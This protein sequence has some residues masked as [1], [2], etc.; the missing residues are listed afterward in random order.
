MAQAGGET[1]HAGGKRLRPTLVYLSAPVGARGTP[2]VEIAAAAVELVHMATLVHDDVLDEAP[3]R[4]GHPTAWSTHGEAVAV[5][6]GDYLFARAFAELAALRDPV[7]IRMLS[8]TSC[9][10]A[11]GELLQAQQA[12]DPGVAAEDVLERCRLKTG[13]LFAAACALGGRLGGLDAAACAAL[14]RFG[15]SLGLAFQLAD[16]V[17]DCAGDPK[18]TGKA[19]GTDLRDGTTSLPLL[20][21]AQA[22][23]VLAAAL[24]EPVAA[25][26]V[27][28]LLARVAA[29]GALD[30]VRDTAERYA[31]RAESELERAPGSDATAL[32]ALLQRAIER[33][34]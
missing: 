1:L 18:R 14:E 31:R 23:P 19:L 16:D 7:S 13:R 32:R 26:D 5:A 15:E 22:D 8:T 11:R 27:L 2:A 20:L 21:A 28:P 4:R 29:T 3:L 25:P 17:L 30:Q 33:D 12:R 9:E 24:R 34:S 10:L 6:T